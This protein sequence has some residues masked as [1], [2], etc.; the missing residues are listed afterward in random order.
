MHACMRYM[1]TITCILLIHGGGAVDEVSLRMSTM[2]EVRSIRA[3]QQNKHE[4]FTFNELREVNYL[5]ATIC[6]PQSQSL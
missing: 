6:M 5:H 3:T 2:E 1:Y 4:T